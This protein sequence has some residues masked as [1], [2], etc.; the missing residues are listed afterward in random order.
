MLVKFILLQIE[1]WITLSWEIEL[2]LL[3]LNYIELK[4]ID[5]HHFFLVG[6]FFYF[7]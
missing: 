4:L 1:G 5:S 3:K 2:H 6:Y 7:K